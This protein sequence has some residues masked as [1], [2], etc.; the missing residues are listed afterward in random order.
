MPFR[1]RYEVA[2]GGGGGG[3]IVLFGYVKSTIDGESIS[4]EKKQFDR[5]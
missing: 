1:I 3:P 2:E 4:I 5:R